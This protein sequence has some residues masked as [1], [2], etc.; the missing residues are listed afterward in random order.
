MPHPY[1][2]NAPVSKWLSVYLQ[3][4]CAKNSQNIDAKAGFIASMTTVT[5]YWLKMSR[6]LGSSKVKASSPVF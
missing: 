6:T 1:V 5:L 2:W 4:I 3:G